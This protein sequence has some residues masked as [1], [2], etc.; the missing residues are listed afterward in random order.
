MS[1]ERQTIN[2]PLHVTNCPLKKNGKNFLKEKIHCERSA[3]LNSRKAVWCI[4]FRGEWKEAVV[5]KVWR[6]PEHIANEISYP[7]TLY[8]SLEQT[9]LTVYY[10]FVLL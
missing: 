5:L 9:L 7:F 10:K 2:L 4:G 3:P 6:L 8:P 1:T